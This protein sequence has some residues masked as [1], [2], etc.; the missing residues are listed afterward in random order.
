MGSITLPRVERY[1]T[2]SP[3]LVNGHITFDVS[4]VRSVEPMHHSWWWEGWKTITPV[5]THAALNANEYKDRYPT[6][7]GGEKCSLISFKDGGEAIVKG[8]YE[9]ITRLIFPS[10]SHG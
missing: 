1:K 7:I 9:D 3:L 6:A 5:Q 10:A 8:H 2:G 4:T